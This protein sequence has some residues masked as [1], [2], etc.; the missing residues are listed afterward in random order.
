MRYRPTVAVI[1][2]DAVRHN[3]RVLSREGS[4]YMAVVKANG[5]GHGAVPIA[6]AALDAGAEWLGV[7]LVEEGIAL[8]DAG[9]TAPVLVLTEFPRGSEKEALAADLTPVLYTEEGIEG[10]AEAAETLGRRARVHVKVDTGMHRVG[11]LPDLAVGFLER[12]AERGLDIEGIL[13]HFA[14]SE[15]PDD[16][17][18]RQQLATFGKLLT[19]LSARGS[20][21]PICHAANTAASMVI[22]ESRLDLIRI[23]I[24]TYGIAPDPSLAGFADLRP[25][26]SFR[27]R[28][29]LVKRVERG[30]AVSYG[31]T[32]R[33][34][35]D[36]T[37]ATVPVGYADGFARSLSNRARVL[38][39]GQRYPVVG[40]VTMD[41]LL[42]DCG[43]DPVEAGDEVVLW[44]RQDDEEIL[45]EDV[46]AWWG[47]TGYEVVCAVSERVPREYL[48]G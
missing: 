5:Y 41:Q 3:V 29:S 42:V 47:T 10:L 39:R 19:T 13:T 32:Y 8:R 7:A 15:A 44:G 23:G 16:P 24:G 20:R 38:I 36:A 28:V 6:R 17:A 46:A 22:P 14:K 27:S 21:P 11:L 33:L 1:D 4:A 48:H 31:F 12:A 26:M 25:V 30:H 9:I 18:T 34:S 35:R 37:I 40:T 43:D 45:A 2:L